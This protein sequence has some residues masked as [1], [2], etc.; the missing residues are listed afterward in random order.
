MAISNELRKKT[1]T[2]GGSRFPMPNR[3]HARLALQMLPKAKNISSAE[4]AQVRARA[5]RMLG[6]KKALG[7]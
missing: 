4:E 6:A 7:K 5:N 3:E 2:F 1:A